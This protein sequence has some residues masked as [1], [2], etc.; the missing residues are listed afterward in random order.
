MLSLAYASYLETLVLATITVLDFRV[1][2]CS[3]KVRDSTRSR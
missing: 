2:N 1:L 3:K